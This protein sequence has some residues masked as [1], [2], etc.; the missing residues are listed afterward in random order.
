MLLAFCDAS[1][2]DNS[3]GLGVM[4]CRASSQGERIKVDEIIYLY[5]RIVPNIGDHEKH[6]YEF[7]S[8]L[9]G[10]AVLKAMPQE[11]TIIFND[12][13]NTVELLERL[14]SN[15]AK[16]FKDRDLFIEKMGCTSFE[17]IH[18]QWLPRGNKGIHIADKLSKTFYSY[19]GEKI[20]LTDFQ[21]LEYDL[22]SVHFYKE[23]FSES[24]MHHNLMNKWLK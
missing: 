9:E 24:L 12:C 8:I 19:M 5:K 6:H 22:K 17:H 10:L 7:Y 20:T 2:L 14:G 21:K 13:T 1:I 4:V 16:K 15:K 3:M 23:S 11:D 18:F